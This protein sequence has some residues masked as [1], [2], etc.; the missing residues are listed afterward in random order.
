VTEGCSGPVLARV[1][2]RRDV[3]AQ[4]LAQLLVPQHPGARLGAGHHLVWTLF[5]DG[6]DRR[7]DFLWREIRAGEFLILAARSPS[8]PHRLFDLES[9]PFAPALR[10]GQQLRFDLRANPV[11]SI[12]AEPGMRGKRH[13]VVMHAISNLGSGERA[14]AREGAIREAGSAWLARKGAA[15]GF[16]IQPEKLYTDHYER[17]RVPRENERA[18]VFS[19][20]TFQGVLTVDEPAQFVASL[21]RGFGAAKAYGCGLML[22]RRARR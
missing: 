9:K 12:P 7:R 20:L 13:D 8:D 10:P 5:A 2:L 21:L 4:A 19:V 15:A 3:P 1:R 18:V 6:R 17:V 11:I 22:I 14:A 16:R